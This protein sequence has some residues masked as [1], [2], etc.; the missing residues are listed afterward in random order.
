MCYNTNHVLLCDINHS[1]ISSIY[2]GGSEEEKQDGENIMMIA[3]GSDNNNTD[4]VEEYFNR[5]E[6]PDGKDFRAR[7]AEAK[8]IV[9]AWW[10]PGSELYLRCPE[11]QEYFPG[12][13]VKDIRKPQH[14]HCSGDCAC[15]TIHY[16]TDKEDCSYKSLRTYIAW[17]GCERLNPLP[18]HVWAV[19]QGGP[20][21]LHQL[22]NHEEKST[23]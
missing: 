15:L 8:D 22:E 4:Y 19:M 17:R 2:P 12:H 7:L 11:T 23:D 5:W 18:K 1:H 9:R 3:P 21:K 20:Y 13:V 16:H 14:G 10:R 6:D